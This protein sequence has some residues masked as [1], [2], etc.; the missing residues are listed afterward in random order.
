MC[1]P[2]SGD[3]VGLAVGVVLGVD[4]G[5]AVGG[6]VPVTV[7]V[8]VGLAVADAVGVSVGVWL[9]V[10]D[11]VLLGVAVG[12]PDAVLLGVAVGASGWPSQPPAHVSVL[13]KTVLLH[14]AATQKF[15]QATEP[16][17]PSVQNAVPVQ[18]RHKQ[19]I[20][21]AGAVKPHCT[22]TPSSSPTVSAA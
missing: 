5:V 2:S 21:S 1:P 14:P 18:L 6:T 4:V 20:A 15:A 8:A 12:V 19:H 22:A 13:S 11:T 17:T 3:G 9:G 16:A 7:G 10:A